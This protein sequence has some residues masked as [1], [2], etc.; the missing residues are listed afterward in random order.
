MPLLPSLL[1]EAFA[2]H[3]LNTVPHVQMVLNATRDSF[4]DAP[5]Q[6]GLR[7]VLMSEDSEHSSGEGHRLCASELARLSQDLDEPDE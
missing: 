1:T 3:L 4:R 7:A 6:H 2:F 5:W